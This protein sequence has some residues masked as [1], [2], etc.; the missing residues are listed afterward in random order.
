[1]T[2]KSTKSKVIEVKTEEVSLAR[3]VEEEAMRVSQA[4]T[5][6]PMF[7]DDPATVEL[8][9]Q[10]AAWS[11]LDTLEDLI[12]DRKQSYREQLLVTAEQTGVK[13]DK[14]GF[15]MWVDNSE[16]VRER[17]ERKLP[18]EAGLK[19][20]MASRGIP[21]NECFDEVKTLVLN[22]SKLDYLIE[23]GRL[24][25]DEV[26]ALKKVDWALKVSQSEVIQESLNKMV[27]SLTGEPVV[28]KKLR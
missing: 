18:E 6:G 24:S 13:T 17:R 12:K 27:S 2:K 10:V 1:M 28:R 7:Q 22:P 23:T 8:P 9:I 20:L 11:V 19:L 21:Y 14:G 26:D 15:R 5:A 16:V 25:K 3:R 4:F